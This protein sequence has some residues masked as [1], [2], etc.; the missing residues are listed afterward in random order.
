V[1]RLFADGIQVAWAAKTLNTGGAFKK[2]TVGVDAWWQTT[3]HY[4]TNGMVD[5]PKVYDYAL[6][7]DQ[8]M[9]LYRLNVELTQD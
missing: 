9:E 6:S 4:L 8:V 7:P 3:F 2:F 1:V 5:E